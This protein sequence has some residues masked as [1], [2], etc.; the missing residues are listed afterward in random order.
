M[1]TLSALLRRRVCRTLEF[2]AL[3]ALLIIAGCTGG[4]GHGGG[5]GAGGTPSISSVFPT[6][7]PVGTS[8]TITGFGFGATQGA[9]TV[10][11]NGTA[12]TV[13]SWSATSITVTVPAGATTGNVVVT[14]GGLATNGV[15][16][17]VSAAAAPNITSLTPNSGP[18]GTPVVIA[19]SNFGVTQGTS[20]ILFTG[21]AV[22]AAV[23]SW[24]ATSITVT[25]PAGAT[26]GNVTVTVGG[27]VS[28]GVTFTVSAVAA[29][30]ITSLTPNSGRVGTTVVI[31]GSNFGA[32][33]ATSTVT[34]NGTSAGTA[35]AWSATSITVTVPAGATTGS[36]VV[37]VGGVSSNGV[38]FTVTAAAAPNI[39]SLTPNSGPV[40]TSVVIAGTN[41]GATQGTSTVTF[42]GTSIGSPTAWSATSIT[43]TVPAGA[44]TGSVVVTVSGVASNGVTFT[45][46][47]GCS[48]PKLGNENLLNGPYAV[49]FNGWADN[50]VSVTQAAAAFVANGTTALIT[51]GEVDAGAV[52]VGV[53]QG[54][55]VHTTFT[56]CFNLGA[57][58]RGLMI[59]NSAL[60]QSLTFAFA[61]RADGTLGRFV[62]F[63]DA[64]PGATPGSRGAGFFEKQVLITATNAP[65]AFGLTGYSPNSGGNDYRRSGAV[66]VVGNIVLGGAAANGTVDV[67][68][69]N[70]GTGAQANV[71]NQSFTATFSGF[72]A[73]GHGTASL[74]FANFTGIG[75]LTLNFAY[76]IADPGHLFL[77]STDMPDNNGHSLENGEVI[78]Q[79]GG[80]YS[81]AS[82]SSAVFQMTGADLSSNHAFTETA[83]GLIVNNSGAVTVDLDDVRAGSAIA[84]GAHGIPNGS[85]NI[86]ANGMGSITIGSCTCFSSS[87]AAFSVAMYGP[88]AGFILEGTQASVPSPSTV[89]IG[90]FG[91]Q[92]TPT[93]GFVDGT[94]SGLYIIGTDHPAATSS[95]NFV[96]SLTA[97]PTPVP[98]SFSG[99]TDL[100]AGSP[101]TTNCLATDQAVTATYMVDG[102]GRITIT[103]TSG[104]G[105]APV[106]WLRDTKNADVLSDPSSLN[107]TILK[108]HQ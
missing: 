19:G 103:L 94:F 95:D 24:S 11:F 9:S 26:T 42:N 32:T 15:T 58:H 50:P 34:F 57:D 22:S 70:D 54:V 29:P 66:G 41:F 16:F 62:E 45:V 30:N 48:L 51:S 25:V 27:V 10:T 78:P 59:W 6:A 90:D 35:T 5:G 65:V 56:G 13:S 12:A 105:G 99:K 69:T 20:T 108:V 100:S 101:C 68:Y 52:A 81:N 7:G 80:P 3:L 76:Y 2:S 73:L 82:V 40:G 64:N 36:V 96:G 77:Q 104:G 87:P 43:V 84:I 46:T 31:A 21:T 17:T 85:L 53:V 91:P 28:N 83:V 60:G 107:G 89:L 71:D 88:S 38:T 106:G 102:N 39:T 18:V 63:D 1:L 72:D 8:V 49:L 98:A 93:G 75:A 74:V 67:A 14:V 47:V 33:Q 97:N 79:T 86:S 44:T 92:T 61:I 4:G 37:K 55:P 23:T